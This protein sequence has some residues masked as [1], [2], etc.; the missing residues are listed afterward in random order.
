MVSHDGSDKGNGSRS[1]LA[2]VVAKVE[3]VIAWH[4]AGKSTNTDA[5]AE[6]RR[7]FD[8]DGPNSPCRTA[9]IAVLYT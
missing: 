4:R 5:A 1:P 6:P 2:K 3:G 8:D 9:R 7:R